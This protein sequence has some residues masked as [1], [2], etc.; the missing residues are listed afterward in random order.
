MCE[1]ATILAVVS[2]A[3]AGMSAVG[4]N[5][6]AQAQMDSAAQARDVQNQQLALQQK[7]IDDA[8][9]QEASTRRRQTDRE[10][11]QF[12]AAAGASGVT[13]VSLGRQQAGIGTTEALDLEVIA[14]NRE[15]RQQQAGIAGLQIGAQ[16]D[17][18]VSAAEASSAG[19]LGTILGMGAAGLG[20]YASG[21]QI[22]SALA[23]RKARKGGS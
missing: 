15:N 1:P 22:E 9:A 2:A 7:Q 4:A 6:Q 19:P 5:Q 23:D 20:G 12:M 16:F 14:A 17:S 18:R 3:S 8:A 13:G 11:A 21:L 10:L